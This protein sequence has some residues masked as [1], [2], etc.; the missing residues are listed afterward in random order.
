MMYINEIWVNLMSPIGKK[1][2]LPDLKI[3]TGTKRKNGELKW[4]VLL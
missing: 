4:K 2:S 3:S 1:Y